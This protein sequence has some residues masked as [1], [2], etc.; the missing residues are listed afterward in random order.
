M[1]NNTNTGDNNEPTNLPD[2]VS[3]VTLD[4]TISAGQLPSPNRPGL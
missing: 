3:E 1:S 4:E 2:P